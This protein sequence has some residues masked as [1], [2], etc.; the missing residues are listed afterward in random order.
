[1]MRAAH[2]ADMQ[3][4]F[5]QV[6]IEIGRAARDVTENIL[7]AGRLADLVEIVV[8]LVGEELLAE[9][10]HAGLLMLAVAR[11]ASMMGS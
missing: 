6:I 10:N 7:S 3:E 1:M 2:A 11:M 5:E 9:L 8:T 4:A